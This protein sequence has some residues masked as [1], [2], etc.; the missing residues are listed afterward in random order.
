MAGPR[1]HIPRTVG[2]AGVAGS[3]PVEPCLFASGSRCPR[4]T[5][6]FMFSTSPTLRQGSMPRRNGISAKEY[7]PTLEAEERPP[8]AFFLMTAPRHGFNRTAITHSHRQ[9]WIADT[10]V[11]HIDAPMSCQGIRV[12]F[13]GLI[14]GVLKDGERAVCWIADT[15]GKVHSGEEKL[16]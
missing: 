3:H 6:A 12:A 8:L 9:H 1:A 4:S 2:P 11:M 5:S 16:L 15:T 7:V 14:S 10:Q 13:P